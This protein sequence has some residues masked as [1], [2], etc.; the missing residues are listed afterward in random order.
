MDKDLVLN[1]V[2]EAL[3][4]KSPK[5]TL[6]EYF[7][8]MNRRETLYQDIRE[9]I[10]GKTN[11]K[12]EFITSLTSIV[13]NSKDII[14]IVNDLIEIDYLKNKL[15]NLINSYKRKGIILLIILYM[16]F[17]FITSTLYTIGMLQISIPLIPGINNM[18]SQPITP[19]STQIIIYSIY[20]ESLSTI[21]LTKIFGINTRKML[22]IQITTYI[23]IYTL[24][25]SWLKNI[26]PIN[27]SN[28]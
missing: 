28:L 17:P 16:I 15:N 11:K 25:G 2:N 21:H 6:I 18:Q 8:L 1:I 7:G 13:R 14:M 27:Y 5:R 19:E 20:V 10:N 26:I 4:G 12:I 22:I 9:Q 23:L 24:T 3:K